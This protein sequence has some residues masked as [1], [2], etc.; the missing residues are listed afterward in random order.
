MP[1]LEKVKSSSGYVCLCSCD[2]CGDKFNR[3]YFQVLKSNKLFCSKKCFIAYR[4]KQ[5]GKM[6]SKS[7]GKKYNVAE[8]NPNWQGGKFLSPDGY[9]LIRKPE[10]PQANHLGYIFEHRYIM[11][12]HIGR[13]LK[14]LEMVHHINNDRTDNRITNL[15]L[16]EN[17]AEHRKIHGML[18]KERRICNATD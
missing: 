12:Q 15:M 16:C 8:N 4:S 2:E 10:H 1:I 9:V 11:E 13:L 14:P 6:V 18:N 7:R 3:S 17:N 5:P